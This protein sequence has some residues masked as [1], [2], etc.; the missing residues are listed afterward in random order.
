MA[1]QPEAAAPT[2][3]EEQ[4]PQTPEDDPWE[5]PAPPERRAFRAVVTSAFFFV[6]YLGAVVF[7]DIEGTPIVAL[8]LL[9]P[10]YGLAMWLALRRRRLREYDPDVPSPT[11]ARVVKAIMVFLLIY[12]PFTFVSDEIIPHAAVVEYALFAVAVFFLMRMVGR[13]LGVAGSVE[14]LP[15]AHHRSHQQVVGSIDDPH[16]QE[17]VMQQF[18]FVD[19]GRGSRQL[20]D[21]L[22]TVLHANGV[23]FE[24][25]QEILAPIEQAGTGFLRSVTPGGRARSERARQ[26]RLSALRNVIHH[27]NQELEGIG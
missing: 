8:I 26:R 13:S 10:P 25:I 5:A 11:A 1:E 6:V 16:Y 2:D 23:E 22:S 9:G 17:T 21:R 3:A 15:P 18:T 4:V 12:I 7:I 14:A 27:F 20:L 24:R 19:R